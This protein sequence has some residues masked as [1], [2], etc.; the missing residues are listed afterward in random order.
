[1]PYSTKR[2]FIHSTTNSSRHT[3]SCRLESVLR[4]LLVIVGQQLSIDLSYQ[5]QNHAHHNDHSRTRDDEILR[6][7]TGV[8]G[9]DK[10]DNGDDAEEHAPPEVEAIAG[11]CEYLSC[12]LTGSNTGDKAAALLDVLCY[13][14]GAG[15]DGEGEKSKKKKQNKKKSQRKTTT[16]NSVGV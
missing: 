9:E 4:Q 7:E 10:R 6:A 3:E 14:L 5:F 1:M 11:F 13:L 15:R 8:L 12:G 16:K 2:N